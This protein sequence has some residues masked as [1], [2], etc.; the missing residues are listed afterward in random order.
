MQSSSAFLMAVRP[1]AEIC[2][3]RGY[4]GSKVGGEAV[5]VGA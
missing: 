3:V 4:S 2:L 1:S 5:Y